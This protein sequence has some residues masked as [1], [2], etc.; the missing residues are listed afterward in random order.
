MRRGNTSGQTRSRAPCSPTRKG[1]TSHQQ[2]VAEGIASFH[3][4]TNKALVKMAADRRAECGPKPVFGWI[5]S[6]GRS[7]TVVG[8]A[9]SGSG[10]G[11]DAALGHV[12]HDHRPPQATESDI[13]D[14]P[15]QCCHLGPLPLASTAAIACSSPRL[16]GPETHPIARSGRSGSTRC[17]PRC[18][19][20]VGVRSLGAAA[21]PGH[22]PRGSERHDR[23]HGMRPMWA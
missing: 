1:S 3:V 6:S 14:P 2:T 18:Q 23:D 22:R 7:R 21:S 13:C 10:R 12:A 16:C 11:R 19:R 20:P 15:L 8:R 4:D 5:A 17:Q 9:W